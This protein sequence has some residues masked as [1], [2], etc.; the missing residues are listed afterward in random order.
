MDDKTLTTLAEELARLLI[1]KKKSITLAES[2]SGGWVAKVFTDLSGSSEWFVGGFVSY[3]N[4]F[5]EEVLGVNS[6][7]LQ[8]Y[9]AVSQE[10]VEAMALGALSKS[11]ADFSLAISGIAG[12]DGGTIEKPVGLVWFAWAE[13]NKSQKVLKSQK[14]KFGGDRLSVRRQAVAHAVLEMS[15]L[16]NNV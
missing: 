12:P 16:L 9:G 8:K 1:D 14:Q 13:K 11:H 5:K 10:T 6:S 2:C 15:K 7:I 3:S 4:Q